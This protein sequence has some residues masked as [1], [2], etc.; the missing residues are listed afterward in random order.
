MHRSHSE[1]SRGTPWCNFTLVSRDL[2][3]SLDDD[4]LLIVVHR[5]LA[6]SPDPSLSSG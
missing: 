1:R 6:N 4:P 3:I 5:S 2:A